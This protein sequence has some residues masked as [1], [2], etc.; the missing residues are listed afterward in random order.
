MISASHARQTDLP[1]FTKKARITGDR[2]LKPRKSSDTRVISEDNMSGQQCQAEIQFYTQMALQ[3]WSTG[4]PLPD[5]ICLM[6]RN[7]F[8]CIMQST[9]ILGGP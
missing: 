6:H 7:H 5:Q 8:K 3:P 4:E 1:D 9:R 2:R